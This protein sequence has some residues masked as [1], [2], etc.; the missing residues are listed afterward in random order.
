MNK[1]LLG[2]TKV[3]LS[4]LPGFYLIG[5]WF[6]FDVFIQGVAVTIPGVLGHSVSCVVVCL[7]RDW[8]REFA[9]FWQKIPN[10]RDFFP[11]CAAM[12]WFRRSIS[13][14]WFRRS[15]QTLHCDIFSLF[16]GFLF[17]FAYFFTSSAPRLSLCT[18]FSS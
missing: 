7:C 15:M 3:F 10:C 9:Y 8:D 18:K 4:S 12:H 13:L 2:Q 1:L 6:W 17:S 5:I 16:T 14:L 11:C